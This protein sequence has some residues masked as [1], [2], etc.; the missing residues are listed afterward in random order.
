LRYL[1]QF[2]EAAGRD[3]D[4]RSGS[5]SVSRARLLAVAIWFSRSGSVR[6]FAHGVVGFLHLF[7]LCR[8]RELRPSRRV[9]R[10]ALS[11][12][13][14]HGP[15]LP[16]E[17]QEWT[18]TL[19]STLHADT[20]SPTRVM[21]PAISWSRK[22]LGAKTSHVGSSPILMSV[23]RR[24]PQSRATVLRPVVARPAEYRQSERQ[25]FHSFHVRPS[26]TSWDSSMPDPPT[27]ETTAP[28]RR[29]RP[30]GPSNRQSPPRLSDGAF[31]PGSLASSVG[32][33]AARCSAE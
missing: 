21:R 19:S 26:L 17:Q 9:S 16:K 12:P 13:E 33:R 30:H 18:M 4:Q 31:R 6:S 20:P 15:R 32:A 11:R 24:W 3:G 23:C 7:A 8:V 2:S 27:P 14:M 1:R 22:R 5:T 25:Q 28:A 10:Y 29:L